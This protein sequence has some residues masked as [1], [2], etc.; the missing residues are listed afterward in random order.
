M[1]GCGQA[2]DDTRRRVFRAE[3]RARQCWAAKSS[4]GTRTK[5]SQWGE[6]WGSTIWIQMCSRC[7]EGG[8]WR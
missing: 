4:K 5:G 3:H 7:E 1:V 6:G 2:S 8:V